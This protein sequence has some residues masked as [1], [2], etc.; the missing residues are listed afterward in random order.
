M[1]VKILK[2]KNFKIAS[3]GIGFLLVFGLGYGLGNG[4]IS[5]HSDAEN[6][7]LPKSLDYSL[8][9]KEY[10]VIKNNYDGKLSFNTLEDGALNGLASATGDPHTNYFN[11]T[12]TKSFNDQLNNTFSGI[13]AELDTNS[14]NQTVVVS[15]IKGTP[16]QKAGLIGGDII[17]SV[18]G[19]STQNESIDNVVA[20][21]HGPS[22][23]TVILT[24][25]RSSQTLTL[26][27]VR[28]NINLPS[29][30][31]S[32]V[33]GNIGYMDIVDFATDTPSLSL[34]AADE[35]K[36][37]NVKGI[38]LDLRDNPGGLVSSAVSVSSLWL[39]QG[40]TIMT[41]K[42]DNIAVQTYQATGGDVLNGIPTVVLINSG[43]ASA[44]EITAGALKDDHAATLIGE[45]SYGKG[46]VQ[47]IY[48]LSQGKEIKVTIYHWYTPDN[49]NIDKKGITPDIIVPITAADQKSGTDS[50]LVAAE[51][52]IESH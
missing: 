39:S 48:N 52:Y 11:A 9:Q 24:I 31:S 15:T 29:V 45:R 25:L 47:E 27:I 32:I 23:S 14:N 18:N 38:I 19:K 30:S 43:S 20:S 44:S 7:G 35:F 46:S 50:Q 28:A 2:N 3:L 10:A 5:L 42:H 22:G 33:D 8:L 26:K 51:Q 4:Y 36:E 6:K 12:Q 17:T 34:K 1:R 13:G 21:I 16:A 49:V 40:S 37:K 41:E